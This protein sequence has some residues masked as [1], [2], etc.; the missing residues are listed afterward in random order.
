[1]ANNYASRTYR[2]YPDKV[3]RSA[4]GVLL[5]DGSFYQIYPEQKSY[6]SLFEWQDEMRKAHPEVAFVG[7]EAFNYEQLCKNSYLTSRFRQRLEDRLE[8]YGRRLALRPRVA[9]APVAPATPSSTNAEP[10]TGYLVTTIYRAHSSGSESRYDQVCL[11]LAG[12]SKVLQKFYDDWCTDYN[13]PEDWDQEDMHVPFPSR[14]IFSV[15]AL[16]KAA[17]KLHP[18]KLWKSVELW[19]PESDWEAQ[20]PVEILLKLVHLYE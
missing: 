16:E 17:T 10:K 13:Y 8:E 9:P 20:K 3:S 4:T 11:T 15:A 14:D 5:K 12:A 7:E 2:A 18:G 19:G 6:Y 1:M